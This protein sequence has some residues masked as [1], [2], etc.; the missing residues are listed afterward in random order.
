MSLASILQQVA[1]EVGFTRPSLNAPVAADASTQQWV[2]LLK[3]AGERL[4]EEFAWSAL[5]TED[6]VT[7]VAGQNDY[8]MPA[9]FHRFVDDTQWNGSS[10]VPLFG[11]MSQQDWAQNQFGMINVGPFFRQQLRGSTLFLQ[12]T[13]TSAQTVSFYYVSK[14][15]VLQGGSVPSAA[16]LG[17]SDTFQLREDL[18]IASLKWR[19]LRAKRLSYDEER[20]EFD[21]LFIEACA[22]DRGARHLSMDPWKEQDAPHYGFVVP[23]TGF[24]SS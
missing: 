23:L 4:Y 7:T 16:F 12:P 19:W 6:D 5:I 10:R 22:Q 3:R 14:Y 8:P 20:D 13:P 18:L 1:D 21:R 2:A 11:P 24:G 9:D 17:D 15:W